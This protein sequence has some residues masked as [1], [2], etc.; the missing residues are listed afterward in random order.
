MLVYL[1][2][3]IMHEKKMGVTVLLFQLSEAIGH[4]GVNF[5]HVCRHSNGR[6]VTKTKTIQK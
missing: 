5:V 2:S 4:F 6:S 1:P 3:K